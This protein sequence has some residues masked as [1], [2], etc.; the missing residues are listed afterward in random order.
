MQPIVLLVEQDR[1][2]GKRLEFLLRLAAYQ[3]RHF[4]SVEEAI[5][6]RTTCSADIENKVCLLL[7]TPGPALELAVLL[8]QLHCSS[9]DLPVVLVNRGSSSPAAPL[10]RP[11]PLGCPGV[12][13]SEPTEIST[14]LATIFHQG[15][16]RVSRSKEQMCPSTEAT[17]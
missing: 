9:I 5:N 10:N 12:L 7:G 13:V 16:S 2:R 8:Q 6:W 1:A 4:A 14:A 3:V 15:H 11:R 17:G